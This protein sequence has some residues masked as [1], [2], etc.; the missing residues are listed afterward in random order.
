M[1]IKDTKFH[2]ICWNLTSSASLSM[3]TLAA[4]RSESD[5]LPIRKGRLGSRLA[6]RLD[7]I[8]N[9]SPAIKSTA[10]HS[11]GIAG[12]C[13]PFASKICRREVCPITVC[14]SVPA[15]FACNWGMDVTAP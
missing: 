14:D 9:E 1:F 12:P 10:K 7:G 5:G 13:N 4:L 8:Q 15:D 3:R 6:D 11:N 2:V